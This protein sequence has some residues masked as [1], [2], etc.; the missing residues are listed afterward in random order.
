MSITYLGGGSSFMTICSGQDG[1]DVSV[2][3]I[4][5]TMKDALQQVKQSYDFDGVEIESIELLPMGKGKTLIAVYTEAQERDSEPLLL[6]YT[7]DIFWEEDL[8][9]SFK[10]LPVET[11]IRH[12]V[13]AR[14]RQELDDGTAALYLQLLPKAAVIDALFDCLNRADGSIPLF[15][16]AD[17][18]VDGKAPIFAKQAETCEV[19][20]G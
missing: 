5:H 14:F 4:A 13:A 3:A 9:A 11:A 7:G 18:M 17:G 12:I 20:H 8:Q 16:D 2:P 15:C 19:S 1:A 10:A 6:V